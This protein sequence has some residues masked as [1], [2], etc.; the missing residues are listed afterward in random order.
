MPRVRSDELLLEAFSKEVDSMRDSGV[1]LHLDLMV[2]MVVVGN[3]QLALRHPE[4]HQSSAKV[5]REFVFSVRTVLLDR[6]LYACVETLDRGWKEAEEEW[7][8]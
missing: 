4:N 7:S 1:N 2:L 5:A 8:I 3:I 6:R